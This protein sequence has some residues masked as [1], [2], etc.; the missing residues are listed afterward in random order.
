LYWRIHVV[1]FVAAVAALAP[2]A[3]Q[4]AVNSSYALDSARIDH[5][6]ARVAAVAAAAAAADSNVNNVKSKE[7]GLLPGSGLPHYRLSLSLLVDTVADGPRGWSIHQAK[8]EMLDPLFEQLGQLTDISVDSQVLYF[9]RLSSTHVR[10]D[11]VTTKELEGFIDANDWAF[12]SLAAD[13]ETV[14]HFMAYL[15]PIHNFSIVNEDS[16]HAKAFTVPRWGGV[17]IIPFGANQLRWLDVDSLEFSMQTIAA[18]L[19]HMLS[20]EITSNGVLANSTRSQWLLSYTQKTSSTL[21]ALKD[22]VESA[23]EMVVHERVQSLVVRA[24]EN[25]EAALDGVEAFGLL[26]EESLRNARLAA[27]RAEEAFFHPSLL[28]QLYSPPE[29]FFALYTPFLFPVLFPIISGL[30]RCLF[31]KGDKSNTKLKSD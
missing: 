23:A 29:H 27:S 6:S 10:S 21:L 12:H 1:L 19:C 2:A 18:Q 31:D 13:R 30:F 25:L 14:L 20:A 26:H 5:I 22:L 28:P 7:P 3:F 9:S 11:S 16:T 15:P 4:L 8:T 24:L 17:H